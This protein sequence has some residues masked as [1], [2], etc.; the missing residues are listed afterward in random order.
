MNTKLDYF[1]KTSNRLE[2][3]WANKYMCNNDQYKQLN[4]DKRWLK[5]NWI[6]EKILGLRKEYKINDLRT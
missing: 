3:F 5:E 2:H 1:D 4:P 6:Q